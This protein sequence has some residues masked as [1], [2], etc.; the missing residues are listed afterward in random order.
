[1][2]LETK[3]K[4]K[5]RAARCYGF[6]RFYL[7]HPHPWCYGCNAVPKKRPADGT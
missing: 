1:M 5:V 6:G 3:A 2:G 4:R 7:R